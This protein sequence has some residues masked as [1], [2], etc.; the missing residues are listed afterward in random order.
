MLIE[1]YIFY[2]LVIIGFFLLSFFTKQ[3][4]IWAITAVLAAILMFSSFS[5]DTYVY[6]YNTTSGAYSPVLISNTYM[7][8]AGIN[9]IFFVLA[10]ILGLFDIFDK[11]GIKFSKK[12]DR[13]E[14][15]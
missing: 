9:M 12:K 11:Y 1:I 3:E 8:L 6:N 4:I 13:T 7:Y 15:N 14:D 5:I 2:Q 10:L